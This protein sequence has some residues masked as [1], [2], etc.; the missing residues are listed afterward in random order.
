MIMSNNFFITRKEFPND[1]SVI[2]SALLIKSGMIYKNDNGIYTYLPMGLKVMNNIKN[3]IREEMKK[4]NC[5]EL[6]MPSLVKSDVFEVTNR[7]KIFGSELFNIKNRDNIIY[8]LCPTS[9]ELFALL[10]RDKVRSYKDLHFTIYQISNKYR[11]EEHPKYGIIRKKEF[12]MADAY[13]FDAD[14]SGLDI[15]YDKMYQVFK[16]TFRKLG[17]DTLVV[18]SDPSLMKGILSEEF[19]VICDYGDNDIVKCNNCSYCTNIEFASSYNTF[20]REKVKI[21]PRKEV[22]TPGVKSVK[23]LSEYL[24]EPLTNIIKSLVLKVDEKYIM[25][26]LR[27]DAELNILK[28]K[29]I[30][31]SDSITIPSEEELTKFDLYRGSIGPVDIDF[32]IIADNEVK[33]M[34][35]AVCGS[36]KRDY[37]YININPGIDFKV[38]KYADLK[39]F[40]SSSLC[41]RCKSTA[42][43]LRGIEVGNIFKLG[44]A[45]SEIYNLRYLDEKNEFNYVH[46]GSY[47]IGIDRCMAAIVEKNHDEK[48]IIWP[49]KVAPYKVG[50]VIVN[51]NDREAYKYSM[52]LYD[53]LNS[54][55]IDTIVDDRKVSPGNK[56]ND[57]D[58]IGVPIRITV[59]HSLNYGKVEIKLRHE[60][61]GYEIDIN[62]L[63]DEINKIIKEY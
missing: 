16:N 13:S 50:I 35:N 6:L 2:S 54:L 32:E 28:L 52:R 8:N 42:S 60:L 7:E 3:V 40:N 17:L 39:I 63:L 15:S 58:L 61:T 48:G 33:Q 1:E 23:D 45:Y 20:R 57:M 18:A 22:Y 43:I 11:D 36:N 51:V 27:A 4:I 37:H 29:K 44:T 41:P 59:G 53:K 56:F 19:Q 62:Y 5:D 49:I 34:Y 47:G 25:V 55:Q 31:K 10:A 26:L 38:D 30:V 9:E 24:T 21:K 12:I 46:M 14:E